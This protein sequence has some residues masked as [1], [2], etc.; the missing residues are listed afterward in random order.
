[1]AFFAWDASDGELTDGNRIARGAITLFDIIAGVLVAAIASLGL[2]RAAFAYVD[3]SVMTYTIQAVAG[4][5]VA[6]AAVAGVALRRTRRWLVKALGIDENAHKEKE[7]SVHRTADPSLVMRSVDAGDDATVRHPSDFDVADS[8]Q[9]KREQDA[10]KDDPTIRRRFVLGVLVALFTSFTIMIVA[11]YEIMGGSASSLLVPLRDV[12]GLF[13]M[14]AIIVAVVLAGLLVALRGKAFNAALMLVFAFGLCCYVQVLFLNEGL[15]PADGNAIDWNEYAGPMVVSTIVWVVVLLVPLFVSRL[16]R[17]M[18][19]G[20]VAAISVAL[21]IVQG[22]GVASLFSE[23]FSRT[24]GSDAKHLAYEY[25]LTDQG[26]FTVSPK[27]NVI[28]FVLDMYDT[29][30]LERAVET[31]PDILDEMTGFIWYE[32]SVGSMIPTR[33][34]LPFLLTGEYPQKD[35]SFS[36]F[37]TNRYER[38]SFL[39]DV[40]QAGYSMGVYSDTLGQEYMPERR[41]RELIYDRTINIIPPKPGTKSQIDED[42]TRAILMKCALYRDLPWVLK[43]YFWYYTDEVNAAMVSTDPSGFAPGEGMYLFDDARWFEM[44]KASGLTFEPDDGHAGAFRFIHLEGAH[45]PY[46]VDE[47]GNH[48]EEGESDLERQAIGSMRMV[49]AYLAR[50]KALG[51]YDRSTVVIT[52]DHGEFYLT[53]LPLDK[54][55]SPILL[56]KPA[57]ADDEP[58]LRSHAPVSSLD[59]IPTMMAGIEGGD[60]SK[61]G[62]PVYDIGESEH[63]ERLYYETTSRGGHDWRLFEYEIGQDVHDMDS[64]KLTGYEWDLQ[65]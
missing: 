7:G 60:A 34:G 54:P 56:V 40:E 61:Y 14:P 12:W 21:V 50:L 8:C 26:M 23:D 38:S 57:G 17:R 28:V 22:A 47:N 39:D 9:P 49:D 55:S 41:V 63:R 32:N 35:E 6:L 33:Y 44:L 11:P 31:S 30:Y 25:V 29:A 20:V 16:N 62:R 24:F 48:V 1:M 5:A 52:A 19:Q 45:Y 2:P 37:L 53:D 59:V 10:G 3:P 43:P 18:A 46:V 64:W 27:S 15:P 36:S 42:G 4:V 13:V 65:A 58:C 51:V